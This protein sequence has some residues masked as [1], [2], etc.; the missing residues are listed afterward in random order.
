MGVPRV[1]DGSDGRGAAAWVPVVEWALELAIPGVIGG[2]AWAGVARG[3]RWARQLVVRLH[4]DQ[5]QFYVSRG[6]AALIAI[7]YVLDEG[8]EYGVLDVEL[9]E[10][11]S[12]FGGRGVSELNYVGAE[13]WLVALLNE[14]RSRRYI[15]AVSPEGEAQGALALPVSEIERVYLG[16]PPRDA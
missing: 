6:F 14:D 2:A 9:V 13:A 1:V 8:L 7:G 12:R 15:V 3:A 5:V 4:R 16:L 11:L 10:K